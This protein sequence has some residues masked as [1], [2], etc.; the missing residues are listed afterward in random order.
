MVLSPINRRRAY[1]TQQAL[2][3]FQKG[4]FPAKTQ[5]SQR[6]KG[7][8][9]T[10][11]ATEALARLCVFAIF[12]SLRENLIGR[13]GFWRRCFSKVSGGVFRHTYW[14]CVS[15]VCLFQQSCR[16]TWASLDFA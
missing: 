15:E 2:A 10:R 5:R 13:R 4:V 14:N 16:V 12:A 9:K 1:I 8:S 6:R 3:Q 7:G 11:T